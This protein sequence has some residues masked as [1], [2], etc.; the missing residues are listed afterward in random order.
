MKIGDLVKWS[1]MEQSYY[2]AH[3]WTGPLEDLVSCRQRGLIVDANPIY[4]FV[5]WEDGSLKAQK[6]GT[7]E[8]LS[9]AKSR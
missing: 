1:F 3:G 6:P 9:E 4:Y 5:R 7:L 8:V 2:L